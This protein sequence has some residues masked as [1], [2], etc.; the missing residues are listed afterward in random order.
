MRVSFTPEEMR[1]ICYRGVDRR[2]DA[3]TKNRK[4][5]HGFNRDDFWELDIE[6]MLAEAAV[7]KALGVV[8]DPRPGTLDTAWGD[9]APGVQVRSTKYGNGHLLVHGSDFDE[10]VFVLVTGAQGSYNLAGWIQ[11]KNAKSDRYWKTVKQRSAFWIPQSALRP[12]KVEEFKALWVNGD[13]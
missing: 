12:F 9:V 7:A 11:A 10:H 4:G 5:N 8:Y 13:A 2:I 3:L 1:P 6:G